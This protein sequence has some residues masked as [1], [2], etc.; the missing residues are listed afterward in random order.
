[1]QQMHDSMQKLMQDR[2][3]S[4]DERRAQHKQVMET[5][6]KQ[7]REYLNDDQKKKLDDLE[8]ESHMK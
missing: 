4:Q 2:N 5:A 8:Q 6:D 7:I 3:L 1:M